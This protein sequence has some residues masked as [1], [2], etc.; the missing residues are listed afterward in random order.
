MENFCVVLMMN[1]E[2]ELEKTNIFSKYINDKE[3]TIKK[4]RNI[5]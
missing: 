4:R 5:K 2:I 3:K 1:Y